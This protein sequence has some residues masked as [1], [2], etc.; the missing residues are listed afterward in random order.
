MVRA[1]ALFLSLAVSGGLALIGQPAGLPKGHPPVAAPG[2][3]AQ[4]SPPPPARPADV[5]Q[6][7]SIVGAMYSA[8]SAGAGEQRDWDRLRS[9]FAAD[10]RFIAARPGAEGGASAWVL[11]V[12]DY[13]Q[14]NRKYF[15]KGGYFEKE[16]A[17]RVETFGN[18]AHVW[19][20]YESRRTVDAPEPYSRGI[21]SIQLLKDGPRWWIVNVYWDFERPD[22]PIPAKYLQTPKD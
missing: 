21:Y 8:I 4:P 15:E 17:R 14:F 7:D 10:G 6:V 18:I 1:I 2:Q 11:T 19:S 9:L 13:I 12:E 22:C 16:V 3:E 5:A 20:T